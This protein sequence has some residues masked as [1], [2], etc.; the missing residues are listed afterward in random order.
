V[1][2]IVNEDNPCT[3]INHCYGARIARSSTRNA[4]LMAIS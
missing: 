4:L 3:N 2:V 1:Q